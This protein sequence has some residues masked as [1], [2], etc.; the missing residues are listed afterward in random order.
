[1]TTK[2]TTF[3]K[4]AIA[5]FIWSL[6][7]PILNLSSFTPFQNI[8]L[9]DLVVA[10]TLLLVPKF[11]KEII[12][13]GTNLFSKN[14]LIFTLAAGFAGV[15]WL[16][17]LTLL[18]IAQAVLLY[19]S[20]PFFAFLLEVT[21]LK[22]KFNAKRLLA[23]VGGLCGVI[24]ILV[25]GLSL[26]SMLIG[27]VAVLIAAF[28]QAV[29]GVFNK[30]MSKSYSITTIIMFNMIGQIAIS[31]PLAFSTH[32]HVTFFSLAMM[33]FLGFIATLL[34]YYLYVGAFSHLKTSS[35]MLVGYIEPFFAAIW[36]YLFLH[37]ILSPL[38]AFGGA[39]ILAA[40]YLMVRLEQKGKA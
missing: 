38:V 16:K 4:V 34:G 17:A 40:G 1:M 3:F 28:L 20:L 39:I 23:L 7:G 29:A 33:L 19:S 35:I 6:L 27:V 12:H 30:K 37:Q 32:W 31:L 11:R 10:I 14:T 9:A 15:I 18:P 5:Y 24:L 8:F 26:H 13:T 36:G 2:T 21:H 25:G 22:E